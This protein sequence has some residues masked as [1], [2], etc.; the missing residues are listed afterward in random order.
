MGQSDVYNVNRVG[1]WAIAKQDP[2]LDPR[3]GIGLD[4][5]IQIHLGDLEPIVLS[6]GRGCPTKVNAAAITQTVIQ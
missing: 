5:N 1:P 3:R 4:V 2:I 6:V